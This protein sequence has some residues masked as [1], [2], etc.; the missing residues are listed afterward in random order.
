[1]VPAG[2]AAVKV[3]PPVW[4]ALR[5]QRP[6]VFAR[7]DAWWRERIL[8]TPDEHKATPRRLV[9]LDLAR[10]GTGLGP[11]TESLMTRLLARHDRVQIMVGGGIRSI[12]DVLRLEARGAS[13]VLVGSALHD[14]RIGRRELERIASVRLPER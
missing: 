3:P 13:S 14:G 8:R 4:E 10:V 2:A 9:V 5:A 6:G 1:M 12:D 11:G 7:T